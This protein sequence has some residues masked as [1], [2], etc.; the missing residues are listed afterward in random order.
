M[1][2]HQCRPPVPFGTVTI[3]FQSKLDDGLKWRQL[4]ITPGTLVTRFA[5]V[6]EPLPDGIARQTR[7]SPDLTDREMFAE[8]QPP[9]LCKYGH[10]NHSFLLLLKN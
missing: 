4:A 6:L 7:S 9:D 1:E 2:K 3:R 10:G 8:I 5:S